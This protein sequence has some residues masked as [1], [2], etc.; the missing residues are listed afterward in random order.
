MSRY[1][2]PAPPTKRDDPVGRTQHRERFRPTANVEADGNGNGNAAAAALATHMPVG[3][4]PAPGTDNLWFPMGPSVMLHGPATGT[5]WTVDTGAPLQGKAVSRLAN[6]P[7]HKDQW[8]AC[9]TAGLFCLPSG[10]NDWI[11]LAGWVTSMAAQPSKLPRDVV[12]THNAG[13]MR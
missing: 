7:L 10:A 4:M 2:W 8:F 5:P 12:I 13:K 3:D 9:T 1:D 6:D 11:P